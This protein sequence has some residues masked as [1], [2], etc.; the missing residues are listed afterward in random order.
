MQCANESSMKPDSFNPISC[1]IKNLMC[2][3]T[4][5]NSYFLSATLILFGNQKPSCG[6]NIIAEVKNLVPSPTAPKYMEHLGSSPAELRE[7]IIFMCR[8]NG[9]EISSDFQ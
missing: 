5:R 2:F 6:T 1:Y 7:G 4:A 8:G 9:E 3:V